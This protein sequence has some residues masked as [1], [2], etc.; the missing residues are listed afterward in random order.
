MNGPPGIGKSTL[1]ALWV[2]RH[3]GTL[4]LDIDSLHR[5]VGGWQDEETDTWPAVWSLARAMA[6]T[7]L[8]GGN[9]VVLP[10]YVAS[11]H[12]IAGLEKLAASHNAGFREVVLLDDREAAVERF[13]RRA[14]ESD[15]A[16]VCHHHRL[17]SQRGGAVVLR[18]MYDELM[19]V[20]RSLP[21]AVIVQSTAG[22]IDKTYNVLAASLS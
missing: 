4:N 16:W 1:S 6:A 13:D 14:S 18:N 2:D 22:S 20:V 7:H 15:D 12:D 10:Q 21:G 9:D 3:P 17:I 5:M 11:L 19:E 8:D